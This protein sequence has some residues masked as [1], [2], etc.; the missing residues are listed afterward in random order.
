M[1]A[2]T[3]FIHVEPI[4]LYL[5]PL[6]AFLCFVIAGPISAATALVLALRPRTRHVGLLMLVSGTAGFCCV[7]VAAAFRIWSNTHQPPSITISVLF[8]LAG[9]AAFV[10]VAMLF[11]FRFRPA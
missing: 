5:L 2:L 7:S 9:F 3:M 8:G 1:N 11:H 10:A 4:I 6:L